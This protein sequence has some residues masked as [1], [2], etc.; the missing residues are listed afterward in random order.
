MHQ[1]PYFGAR[2]HSAPFSQ[3]FRLHFVLLN[4]ACH[5]ITNKC[6]CNLERQPHKRFF[7]CSLIHKVKFEVAHYY[8]AAVARAALAKFRNYAFVLKHTLEVAET[9]VVV[10][11]DFAR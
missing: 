7:G 4:V 5:D 10:Q 2:F 6:F 8:R 1:L 3:T 11:I 9:V